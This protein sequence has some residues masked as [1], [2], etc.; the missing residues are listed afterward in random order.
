MPSE[1]ASSYYERFLTAFERLALAKGLVTP[2]EL[3]GRTEEY[4]SGARSDFEDDD[5]E[6]GD[7]HH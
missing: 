2:D 7:H 4:A 3:D 6:H 5:H 1:N